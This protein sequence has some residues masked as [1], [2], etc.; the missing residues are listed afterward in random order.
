VDFTG[1]CTVCGIG[2]SGGVSGWR[3]VVLAASA[4]NRAA[5]F[6]VL[7]DVA[8]LVEARFAGAGF[9]AGLGGFLADAVLA[10][11]FATERGA[12]AAL[13]AGALALAFFMIR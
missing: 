11:V 1:A 7:A 3:E 2:A 6:A 9:T 10:L 5:G 8:A 13:R 4:A 12:F